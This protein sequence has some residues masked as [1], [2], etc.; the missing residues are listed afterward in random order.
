[1]PIAFSNGDGTFGVTVQSN[2]IA[3]WAALGGA[4]PLVGDYN[5]DGRADLALTGV[6]GWNSVPVALSRG[7]GSFDTVNQF[8]AQFP[9]WAAT[10]GVQVVTGDFNRD[11][12]TDIALAGVAGG[13]V[14]IAFAQGNG[15]FAVQ[16]LSA[17]FL[18]SATSPG[19]RILV[20]DFNGDGRTDLGAASSSFPT[21]VPLAFCFPFPFGGSN[22]FL[23]TNQPISNFG[24]LATATPPLMG[25]Y[26]GDGRTD[27]ALPVTSGGLL[28]V[29]FSL[30]W[31]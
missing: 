12:R 22:Y 10:S 27:V 29:A 30:S 14:P 1:V 26:N 6:S 31:R 11:Q 5:A 20:G 17:P 18:S 7:D 21:T 13:L 25:D 28:P 4:Q 2:V 19:T 24:G 3:P 8:L 23:L 16:S 15:T 9:G